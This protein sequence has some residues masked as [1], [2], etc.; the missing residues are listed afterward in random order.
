MEW[1]RP[2]SLPPPRV[3]FLGLVDVP[4]L[5]YNT[6]KQSAET[7]C[8]LPATSFLVHTLQPPSIPSSLDDKCI[9]YTIR[10]DHY[11]Y[12]DSQTRSLHCC[13]LRT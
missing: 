2:D 4:G 12:D 13:T 10:R 3:D 9:E 1:S 7:C 8:G 11:Y 5:S 6:Q